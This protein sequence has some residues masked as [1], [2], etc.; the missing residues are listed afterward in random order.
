MENKYTVRCWPLSIT[1]RQ[2][3][4]WKA[5]VTHQP[6]STSMLLEG[7]GQL[8]DD[9]I[10]RASVIFTP[11]DPEMK[12]RLWRWKTTIDTSAYLP[13]SAPIEHIKGS[14]DTPNYKEE[15]SDH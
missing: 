2:S 11:T 14:I 10:E 13:V 6:S 1:V 12:T 3:D 4:R 15:H 5:R 7:P 9:P 8:P